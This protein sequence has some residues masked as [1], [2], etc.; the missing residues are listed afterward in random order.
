VVSTET[1]TKSSMMVVV[2]P[3][4]P[5]AQTA[6][7]AQHATTLHSSTLTADGVGVS[8]DR[9]LL[10]PPLHPVRTRIDATGTGALAV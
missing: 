8:A 4:R 9:V 1:A 7:S 6:A 5:V 3:S 10:Q 2:T